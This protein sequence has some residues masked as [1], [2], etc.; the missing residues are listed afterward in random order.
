VGVVAVMGL[1]DVTRMSLS[2]L[3]ELDDALLDATMERLLPASVEM[4]NRFWG[5]E[6]NPG[7]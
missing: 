5:Q 7:G 3:S 2:A 1:A 6:S 4:E